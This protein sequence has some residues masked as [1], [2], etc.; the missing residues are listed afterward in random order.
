[1]KTE[2]LN[3]CAELFDVPT[4][5]LM[6][7]RRVAPLLHARYALYKAL[8]ARGWSYPAIGRFIGK[9]HSTVL[10]GARQAELL[11]DVSPAYAEKVRRLI[12]F[13]VTHD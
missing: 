3:L 12:D 9:H 2:L 8:R 5:S 13:E 7:R 4:A 1:M 11:M 6:G 10:V